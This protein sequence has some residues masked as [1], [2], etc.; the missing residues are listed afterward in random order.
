MFA[1]GGRGTR[2]QVLLF[3][4]DAFDVAGSLVSGRKGAYSCVWLVAGVGVGSG[5]RGGLGGAA[6]DVIVVV[7]SGDAEVSLDMMC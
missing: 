2:I 6:V 5:L 4:W 3:Q 1:S 7:G